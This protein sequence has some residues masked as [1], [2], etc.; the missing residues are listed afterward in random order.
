MNNIKCVI[1]S[2]VANCSIR[3]IFC[4]KEQERRNKNESDS[5]Y[6]KDYRKFVQPISWSPRFM[7]I[8]FGEKFNGQFVTKKHIQL[9]I[10][11]AHLYLNDSKFIWMKSND[12]VWY[13]SLFTCHWSVIILV[14]SWLHR[15]LCIVEKY[16][17]LISKL[18]RLKIH[19]RSILYN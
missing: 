19:A 16:K 15:Y 1:G 18:V 17:L 13:E 12:S 14:S 9:T 11:C 8:W 2:S 7:Q 5:R 10:L 3:F 4:L 6:N